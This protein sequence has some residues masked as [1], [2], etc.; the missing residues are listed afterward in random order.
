MDEFEEHFESLKQYILD[1]SRQ[2][3]LF[4][5]GISRN[6]NIPLMRPLTERV[7]ALIEANGTD[8]DRSIASALQ[9]ELADDCHVEHYLSHLG[10][11]IALSERSKSNNA[12]LNGSSFT[13]EQLNHC[14]KEIIKSIGVT[15]RYGYKDSDNIG[16]IENPIVDIDSHIKFVQALFTKKANLERR[17]S[18]TF[19]TTNYDTLLEDALAL[20]KIE[21]I[22]GFSGGA[23]AFWNAGFEFSHSTDRIANC[24]LYKLHGSVDWHRDSVYGL[25]RARYGTKYL[26]DAADIMIYP[27]ATKYVETQKDPFAAL[28]AGLR[29]TLRTVSQNVLITCGYSFGD[30]HI[31]SEIEYCLEEIENKTTVV[32]FIEEKPTENIIVNRTLDRWLQHDRFGERVFVAGKNG[33]YNNSIRPLLPDNV[34]ELDWWTFSGLINFI[35]SGEL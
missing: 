35:D 24:S 20:N 1:A 17:T 19:F 28:F 27:Q 13:F 3:W 29:S 21:V 32:V 10:D 22:D 9:R 31:N 26:S 30:E 18:V 14:Y 25:I 33:L 23:M 8:K 15:V 16:T 12:S 5:A 4:G 34:T 11:L 2:S 7:N 6:A